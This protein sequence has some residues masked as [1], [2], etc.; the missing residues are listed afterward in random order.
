MAKITVRSYHPNKLA[1]DIADNATAI[2]ANAVATSY[3]NA[4]AAG[5]H[6]TP[7]THGVAAL[8]PLGGTD[9][10]SLVDA[11]AN[12]L[13]AALLAHMASVGSKTAEGEHLAA[14]GAIAT[15][16]TAVP[17]G[18]GLA[19]TQTLTNALVTAFN[20]HGDSSGVHFHDDSTVAGFTPSNADADTKAKQ[21]TNLNELRAAMAT[22]FALG[23]DDA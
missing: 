3:A 9:A 15:T 5:V 6:M 22:H 16:L 21:I 8:S 10:Q 23:D 13:K 20:A 1:K 2:T 14:E 12:A 4:R 11:R 17:A 19:T 7:A 18:S